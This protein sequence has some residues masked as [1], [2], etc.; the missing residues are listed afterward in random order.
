M[1]V[2]T[3]PDLLIPNWLDL[4]G[5]D[6]PVGNNGRQVFGS[7][8][9]PYSEL[10]DTILVIDGEGILR[11]KRPL[12]MV[13]AIPELIAAVDIALDSLTP[14]RPATWGGIKRLHASP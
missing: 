12:F 11:Y 1:E 7:G 9:N 8:R 10:Y 2:G 3:S 14:V 4:Y 5:W 13:D 6:F